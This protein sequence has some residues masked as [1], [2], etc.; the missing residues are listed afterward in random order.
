[1]SKTRV[2]NF[3]EDYR[4]GQ[5]LPHAVPR[6]VDRGRPSGLHRALPDAFRP[7]LVRRIR[8]RLRPAPQSD[9][10]HRRLPRRVR[11]DGARHQPERRRQPRLC[12]GRFLAPVYPG[13]T[14]TAYERGHRPPRDLERQERRG[15]GPHHRLQPAGRAGAALSAAGSWSASAMRPPRRPSRG[16]GARPGGRRTRVDGAARARLHRATTSRS[17]ASP[18]AGATMRSARGSTTSTA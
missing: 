4:V 8:P 16:P 1:M 11:Q 13:D 14:L 9:R 18:G 2:G 10:G 7:G 12:R 17:P 15:L 3:F 6:T 5:T